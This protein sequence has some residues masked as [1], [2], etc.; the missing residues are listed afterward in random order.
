[1]PG[2]AIPGTAAVLANWLIS[3]PWSPGRSGGRDLLGV[4]L[5]HGLRGH[6]DLGA[7]PAGLV[8]RD[9]ARRDLV[10]RDLVR[11]DLV[12]AARSDHVVVLEQR[13]PLAA[14]HVVDVDAVAVDAVVALRGVIYLSSQ[15]KLNDCDTNDLARN[16]VQSQAV[17]TFLFVSSRSSSMQTTVA[18]K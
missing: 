16:P 3:A 6:V 13:A 17:A 10:R 4:G 15:S 12:K 11:R 7:F 9:L 18:H 8:R 2:P 5:G 1:V 14:G